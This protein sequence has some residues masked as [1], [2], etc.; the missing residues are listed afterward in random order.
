MHLYVITN[1]VNA[2]VYV[3]ITTKLLKYRWREHLKDAEGGVDRALYRAMRRY[4]ADKFSIHAVGSADTWEDLC[5]KEVNLI[6]WFKRK[7]C[8]NMTDGGEGNP[9]CPKSPETREKIR[10]KHLGKTLSDE[11]RMKLSV[12]KL[13]KKMPPRTLEHSA[14]ISEGLVRAHA[15]R[16]AQANR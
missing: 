12:A 4:G 1:S 9:G 11:H 14:R 8:Y 10:Q 13:G 7:N 15:R 2:R 5:L 3:G 16:K 6:R